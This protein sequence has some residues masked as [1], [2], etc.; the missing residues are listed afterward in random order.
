MSIKVNYEANVQLNPYVFVFDLDGTI[1]GDCS[2][3]CDLYNIQEIIKN[4]LVKTKQ[5]ADKMNKLKLGNMARQKALCDK[6]LKKGYNM[7]SKLIR[8]YF[9][10][11]INKMKKI[12]PN[13]HFF[14]YTASE[15]SWAFK[16]IAMI[17]KH[18]NIRFNRP[19]FTRDDCIPGGS[20]ILQK[21]ITKVLPAILK[22]IKVQ[23]GFDIK[24]NILIIDNNPTF[25]DHKT[26]MLVC[27]T[28]NHIEF[29][30]LWETIPIDYHNIFELRVFVNKLIAT[31]KIYASNPDNTNN[32]MLEK[33]HKWLYKK[34]K[35]VNKYNS[36]YSNDTF[37]KDL[38]NLI[39]N[40]NIQIFDK[41]I[42]ATLQKSIKK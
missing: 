29:Q 16:E 31:K 23:K 14:V 18:H 33:I 34:Y 4:N 10:F 2:Y 12:F 20:G 42:V 17:E 27:P 7:K 8:P 35:V 13:S 26:N 38:A 32:I 37:W 19:I 28:Y 25:I 21:S 36:Y 24:N 6:M 30:N 39:S 5:Q 41:K 22:S 3:Q 15:K 11:F 1:I 40:N 9:G